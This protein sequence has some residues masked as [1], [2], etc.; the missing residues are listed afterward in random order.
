MGL[1]AAT[2]ISG[3]NASN[4]VNATDPVSQGDDHLR[5]IK[6]TLLNT[7]PNISGAMNA[8]HTELNHLVGITGKTGTG[9][10]VLSASPTLT[11][12]VTAGTF[13]GSGA[14]LTNISPSAG[15]ANGALAAGVTVNNGNWSGTDLA[16]ANGGTGSSTAAD[17]RTALGLGSLATLS[18]VNNSQWSGT[19]LAVANGGT[20]SSSAS[21]ARTALGVGTM[22]ERNV[23]VSTSAPSGGSNDDI[24][25]VR[26]A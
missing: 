1:E 7:F 2:F 11:G 20:G 22:G 3:L 4:P 12:T 8:S 6:S 24:W 19:D 25:F 5:L 15:I 14:S 21:A 26:E 16:I 23:T 10:V 13:A 17:A 9:N 18:T